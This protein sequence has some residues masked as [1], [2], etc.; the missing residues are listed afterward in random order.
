[1]KIRLDYVSN[2]SSSSFFI[3][4]HQ[5]DW[6]E[7][8]KALKKQKVDTSDISELIE[9]GELRKQFGLDA[10]VDYENEICYLG[11]EFS[12]MEDKE[13]KEEFLARAENNL[14]TLFGKNISVCEICEDVCC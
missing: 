2:S 8:K 6:D 14:K 10:V 5:F 1:M 4:G 3:I 7:L 9:E 13:T 12:S 11:L